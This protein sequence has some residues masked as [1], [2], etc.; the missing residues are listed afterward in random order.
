MHQVLG[1]LPSPIS[2][3]QSFLCSIQVDVKTCSPELLAI[4]IINWASLQ[5]I[6]M[7]IKTSCTC[8]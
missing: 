6:V 2:V 7:K 1:A 5:L 4:I 8:L 3:E